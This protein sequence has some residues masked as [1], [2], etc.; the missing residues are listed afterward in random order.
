M[1]TAK[2]SVV[3]KPHNIPLTDVPTRPNSPDSSLSEHHGCLEDSNADQDLLA[4]F[5]TTELHLASLISKL[6]KFDLADEW[7]H[8]L[9]ILQA[10]LLHLRVWR[11]DVVAD[12]ILNLSSV[13]HNLSR[14]HPLLYLSIHHT[15]CD[16]E[17][18]AKVITERIT[19]DIDRQND[20]GHRYV[21][22]GV[23][24]VIYY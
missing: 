3:P 23:K 11:R 12:T 16:I 21:H 19:E 24:K 4:S 14:N 15:I 22:L 5:Q 13:L 9:T 6:L 2:S 17:H 20:L 18:A 1:K 10:T 8:C 7:T